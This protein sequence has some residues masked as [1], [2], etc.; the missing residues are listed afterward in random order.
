MS[1]KHKKTI[2]II[3]EI[4]RFLWERR[5]QCESTLQ[6]PLLFFCSIR[7]RVSWRK[8]AED[9][10]EHVAL[11]LS[12][13]PPIAG[14]PAKLARFAL[15]PS[16]DVQSGL[17]HAHDTSAML[18]LRSTLLSFALHHSA[19]FR[20]SEWFLT[21]KQIPSVRNGSFASCRFRHMSKYNENEAKASEFYR[22]YRVTI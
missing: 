14:A 18:A 20:N 4:C 6:P 9:T 11:D 7:I 15:C 13:P 17:K 19:S 16:G 3:E 5:L 21:K 10:R 2:N 8:G 12:A 22:N 1:R